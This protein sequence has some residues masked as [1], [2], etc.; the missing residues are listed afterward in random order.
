MNWSQWLANIY[1]VRRNV[2]AWGVA[3]GL[4]GLLL[5]AWYEWPAERVSQAEITVE[6]VSVSPPPAA[7]GKA[8]TVMTVR[9]PDG[10]QWRLIVADNTRPEAGSRVSL[11]HERYADGSESFA[12]DRQ[13]W[14]VEGGL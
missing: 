2:R 4:A 7:Q 6:V 1:I 3:I 10:R 12:F 9:L 5:W 14:L 11:I 8:L 13:R